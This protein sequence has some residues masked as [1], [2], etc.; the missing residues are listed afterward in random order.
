ME[1]SD[2]WI[3]EENGGGTENQARVGYSA[4]G[5]ETHDQPMI[6][7]EDAEASTLK[8]L[9]ADVRDQD[10]LERD[11]GRQVRPMSLLT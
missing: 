9:A 8:A 2:V 11:V 4:D 6:L 3:K 10:D 1:I 5:P 7:K